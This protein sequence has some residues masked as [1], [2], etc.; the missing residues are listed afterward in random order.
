MSK[1]PATGPIILGGTGVTSIRETF[2]DK[3]QPPEVKLSEYYKG[4][5]NV[6]ATVTG[7]TIATSGHEKF[8]D[9]RGAEAAVSIDSVLPPS[10]DTMVYPFNDW[11]RLFMA[12]LNAVTKT[13]RLITPAISSGQQPGI[14]GK[15]SP[16]GTPYREKQLKHVIVEKSEDLTT[17]WPNAA[18]TTASAKHAYNRVAHLVTQPGTTSQVELATKNGKK[19]MRGKFNQTSHQYIEQ[20]YPNF[21]WNV[22]GGFGYRY[23]QREA[24]R[25]FAPVLTIQARTGAA[26]STIRTQAAKWTLKLEVKTDATGNP[27]W[28]LTSGATLAHKLADVDPRKVYAIGMNLTKTKHEL[29]IDGV[30]AWSGP[31]TGL[32]AN[33]PGTNIQTAVQAH[34]DSRLRKQT[35]ADH[36]KE[37]HGFYYS[38]RGPSF[39]ATKHKQISDAIHAMAA[40]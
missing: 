10:V 40:I 13:A 22:S 24:G 29:Y 39:T 2:G 1:I 5:A 18:A 9:Y 31:I 3:P 34:Q 11:D 16:A 20:A 12:N 30:L 25:G 32:T 7:G 21:T 4:G 8:S 15:A 6:P 37:W 14:W 23:G 28:A 35:D 38:Y 36:A 19:Y 33:L 17:F 26:T 27:Y